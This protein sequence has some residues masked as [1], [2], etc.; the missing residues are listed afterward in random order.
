[1]LKNILITS[2]GVASAINV[3]QALRQSKQFICQI[4]ATDMDND[5]VGLY[6]ADHHHIT[7]QANDSHFWSTILKIIEEYKIEFIFPMHSS[8][9]LLFASKKSVFESLGVGIIIPSSEAIH[10]CS[11]KLLFEKFLIDKNYPFPTTYSKKQENIQFPVFIKRNLG[12]SSIGARKINNQ[13]ELR[14]YLSQDNRDYIIQEFIDWQEV[15]VDCYV[16]QKSQLIGCVPRYRVKVKDGKS[17]VSKTL[18]HPK[19]IDTCRCILQDLNFQGAC[20]LQLFIKEDKIKI[21]E[22]NPRLAAGGLP[23]AVA[24]GVNIPELMLQDFFYST[25]SELVEYQNNLTMYRYLTEVFK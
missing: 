20:N 18:F 3:I 16:N 9:T 19:I 1:M 10:T 8:E 14:F 12:S 6:L 5:A 25:S 22:I 17:V 24:A 23:L 2:A 21:I 15:T 13:D 7:P 4:I 11:D